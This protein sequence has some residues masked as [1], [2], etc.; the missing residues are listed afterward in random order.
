VGPKIVRRF[1]NVTASWTDRARGF[2]YLANP[3]GLWILQPYSLADKITFQKQF[4][5]MVRGAVGP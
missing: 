4:D 1:D 3:E 2:I 5:D